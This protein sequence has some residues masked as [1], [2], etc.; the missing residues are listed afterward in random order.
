[1]TTNED[2]LDY[3]TSQAVDGVLSDFDA[4]NLGEKLHSAEARAAAAGHE[5][6]NAL[7]RAHD[8][9]PPIDFDKLAA[10]ISSAISDEV[11]HVAPPIPM[12]STWTRRL[13]YAAA[14]GLVAMAAWPFLSRP[15]HSTSNG[16]M[17]TDIT[18]ATAPGNGGSMEIR[19]G[20]SELMVQRGLIGGLGTQPVGDKDKNKSRVVIT[21]ATG[22]SDLRPF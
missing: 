20:P 4:R 12:R 16:G 13:A 19:V 15:A 1:M 8:P 18:P 14:V 21:S 17:V 3:A 22:P 9:L 7:L 10:S 5:K 2:N 6:I 11:A